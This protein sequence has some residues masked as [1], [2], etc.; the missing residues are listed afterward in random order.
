[1]YTWQLAKKAEKI[2]FRGT[3]EDVADWLNR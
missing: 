2:V 1:M 3:F